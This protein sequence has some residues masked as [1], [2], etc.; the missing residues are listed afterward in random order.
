M[1]ILGIIDSAKTGNLSTTSYESI[2]TSL[3]GAGGTPSVTFNTFPSTY[4]TLQIRC[5]V[6]SESGTPELTVQFNGNTGTNYSQHAVYGTGSGNLVAYGAVSQTFMITWQGA[7]GN[8]NN[9]AVNIID[10][11]D[12]AST[13]K[14]KPIRTL[15]GRDNYGS[16][17]VSQNSG[18]YIANLNAITSITF[19]TQSGT[20]LAEH[21]HF[22]LYGIKG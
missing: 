15:T 3:V 10:I 2:A 21:S 11:M 9:P 17:T 13:N 6:M 4:K 12:Y 14:Y 5:R 18:V 22:A 1:P 20:D 19:A 7:G 16:G 8:T